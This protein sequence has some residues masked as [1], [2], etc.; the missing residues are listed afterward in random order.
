MARFWTYVKDA[1]HRLDVRAKR[2]IEVKDDFK[3][4]ELGSWMY[5]IAIFLEKLERTTEV[6]IWGEKFG[7]AVLDISLRN[8]SHIQVEMLIEQLEI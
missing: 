3:S 6:Q 2:M 4:F 8:L 7:G 5:G 1:S